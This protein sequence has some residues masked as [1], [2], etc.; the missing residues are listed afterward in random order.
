[1][2]PCWNGRD[3][4]GV[5]SLG[6][7]PHAGKS[8]QGLLFPR[9]FL[10]QA[11]LCHGCRWDST[12][13]A[14]QMY[15][16]AGTLFC[17]LLSTWNLLKSPTSPL[18]ADR[19]A[20]TYFLPHVSRAKPLRAPSSLVHWPTTAPSPIIK[21]P[22]I[23]NFNCPQEQAEGGQRTVC[24]CIRQVPLQRRS[25]PQSPPQA[26]KGRTDCLPLCPRARAMGGR[27]AHPSAT[28]PLTPPRC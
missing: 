16:E 19:G 3:M 1:M 6:Q 18:N 12:W 22:P 13:G 7:V 21:G 24:Q 23:G 26:S 28:H 25:W 14:H 9:H 11:C 8:G 2:T 10:G 5:A 20:S 27:S 4:P 15:S 17:G